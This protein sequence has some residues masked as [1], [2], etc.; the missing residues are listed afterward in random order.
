M[1]DEIIQAAMA[2]PE[3]FY[4]PGDRVLY[5]PGD[6]GDRVPLITFSDEMAKR[7]GGPVPYWFSRRGFKLYDVVGTQY[8]PDEVAM[9]VTEKGLRPVDGA[10]TFSWASI[11]ADYGD[12]LDAFFEGLVKF[13]IR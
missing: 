6:N 11:L 1:R 8:E 13:I 2:D 3:N 10:A 4:D 5:G 7:Y 9:V 12:D